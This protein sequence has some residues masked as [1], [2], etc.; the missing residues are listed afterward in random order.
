MYLLSKFIAKEW[1]KSLF[2]ALVVLFLLI[3]IGDIINGFLRSQSAGRVILEYVLKLPDLAGKM[4]PITALLATL[5]SI[6]KLKNQSELM[7]ILAGGYSASRIYRLLILCS[8]SIAILQ[9]TNLGFILPFANKIKRSE[10]EKSQKSESKYLARSKVGESGLIWYKTDNYFASFKAFDVK[11]NILKNITI[12]FLSGQKQLSAIYKANS[13]QHVSNKLWKLSGLVQIHSLDTNN[14]PIQQIAPELHLELG[15][16]PED[17]DQFRA[18][19]TTLNFFDL[20]GFIK[21]LEET[22]INSAEYK[23]MYLEKLSLTLICIVFALFP[24]SGI[25]NPNRRA[26]GFGKSIVITLLFSIVFWGA[27]TGMVSLGNS[28]KLPALVAT[29]GIPMVF[30]GQIILSFYRNRSL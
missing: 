11:N 7:A 6:N 17:F 25:F 22:D 29:M 30:F 23:I 21:R 20:G 1:F 13:A 26:A 27:H 2:G 10:I 24:A 9:F 5:F 28:G 12:Y 4:L 8:T 18:D 14:F 16:T 19:I 15:E 3:S